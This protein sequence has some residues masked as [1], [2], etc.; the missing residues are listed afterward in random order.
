MSL[1]QNALEY[2]A[3]YRFSVIPCGKNKKPLIEWLEFQKR[4]PELEE[5]NDWW[6]KNPEAN[7]GIVTG[8]IS[9]LSVIDIDSK[10]GEENLKQK[11]PEISFKENPIVKTPKGF[12]IYFKCDD[13]KLRNNAGA[14]P[15]C[16]FRANGGYVI[17]PPS[18]NE[19]GKEYKWQIPMR[20]D[21][22]TLPG[23]YVSFLNSPIEYKSSDVK[24]YQEGTRDENL[25]HIAYQLKKAGTPYEE[26]RQTL[27]ILGRNCTPP[28]PERELEAKIESAL[29][30][31][32]RK[33]MNLTDL[34][35]NW[36]MT[37]D[38]AFNMLE[39]F[40]FSISQGAPERRLKE[41]IRAIFK[42]L[43][44]KGIIQKFGEKDGIYTKVNSE[45]EAIDWMSAPT[46]EFDVKYPFDIQ[47]M[48]ITYPKNI[49]VL[50]GVSDSG[51]TA[52]LLNFVKDNMKKHE[53]HY[54]SSEMGNLELK[55]RLLKFNMPLNDWKFFAWERSADFDSVIRPDAIN[56]IDFL[57]IT[58]D[59]FQVGK[60]LQKIYNKLNK[61]IALVALQKNPGAATGLGGYRGMEKPRL[62]LNM[63]IGK[64]KIAKA[65]NWR[66]LENPNGLVQ[67]FKIVQGCEFIPVAGGWYKEGVDERK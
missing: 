66:T 18:S 65:K 21:L 30:F 23:S 44:E 11:F 38:G 39:A 62:Y 28:F 7:I 42:R 17:A 46:D 51:K 22:N 37:T 49:I 8:T 63:D 40:N 25:F 2:C 5:V 34:I 60:F 10:E 50:A 26:I 3:S 16:D 67:E 56:I 1:H 27:L 53:I 45:I 48:F 52:F 61:G 54:F 57:E 64:I 36:V 15:H 19:E 47:R 41:N 20:K 31:D 33:E 55:S 9:N 14:I 43:K 32:N 59:F 12:H 29:K 4:I 13:E 6:V 24:M 35:E 58:E